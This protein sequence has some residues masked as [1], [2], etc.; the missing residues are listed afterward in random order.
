MYEIEYNLKVRLKYAKTDFIP[1]AIWSCLNPQLGEDIIEGNINNINFLSTLKQDEEDLIIVV[2]ELGHL[3][4]TKAE[5]EVVFD[6]SDINRSIK[7]YNSENC[8]KGV[9][10]SNRFCK[11]V[12]ISRESTGFYTLE[13]Y[14]GLY[15]K[16]IIS[17]LTSYFYDS[18]PWF[19][20]YKII[21][22]KLYPIESLNLLP[23]DTVHKIVHNKLLVNRPLFL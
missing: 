12:F 21:N 17:Q 20:P 14:G 13:K 2:K 15:L 10:H 8:N 22:D 6:S 11:D 7:E 23:S 4:C 19:I 3:P 18:F 1:E 9:I 16:D 5:F